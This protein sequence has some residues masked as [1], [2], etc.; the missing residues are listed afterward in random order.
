MARTIKRIGDVSRMAIWSMSDFEVA[1]RGYAATSMSF[2]AEACFKVMVEIA[3]F[4][5]ILD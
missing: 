4:R 2:R 5:Y 1:C 3:T